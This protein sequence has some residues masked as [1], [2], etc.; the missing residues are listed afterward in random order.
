MSTPGSEP[1]VTI[2]IPCWNNRRWLG[3]C[4]DGLQ[5]QHYRDFQ[6]ILVDNG[7]SDGSVAFVKQ[8]YPEIRILSFAK[9]RGFAP[10]VNAGIRQ[11]RSE[12]VALLN[13]DTIPHP[14][15]LL[16]LV[17]TMDSSPP[18]VGSLASKMLKLGDHTIIDDT[19]DVLSWYGSC[20][21]RGTGESA[22]MYNEIEEVFSAC[23]GAALYRRSFLEEMGGFDDSFTSYLEDVDLGLRGRLLGYRC[24]YVPTAK[25]LHQVHGSGLVRSRY[26][27]LITRNRLTLLF[28]N[29]PLALLLK[30]SWTLLY[31]QVYFFLVYKRPFHSLAGTLSFLLA[32]PRILRQRRTIQRQRKISCEAL[33]TMLSNDLEEI[34]LREILGSK[35]RWK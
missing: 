2:V 27:Y 30:H 35:L 14:D 7:S 20:R 13:T 6:V 28:K 31:G 29:I 26:V 21:K 22:E 17:E 4:L 19:G 16:N 12:Y 33:E 5:A 34:P 23:A 32:L 1:Q 25:I 3:G 10:A 8:H 11:T 15:W 18:D 9:N 24:L